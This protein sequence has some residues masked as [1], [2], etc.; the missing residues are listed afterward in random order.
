MW[1]SCVGLRISEYHFPQNVKPKRVTRGGGLSS[2]LFGFCRIMFCNHNVIC[3]REVN[4]P[5]NSLIF[6]FIIITHWTSLAKCEDRTHQS[7]RFVWSRFV[8]TNDQTVSEP[9]CFISGAPRV[10]LGRR[11]MRGCRS[12]LVIHCPLW[13]NYNVLWNRKTL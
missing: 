7:A 3:H 9:K 8:R 6:I 1:N 4:R 5:S 11:G 12:I 13:S 10:F 2:T